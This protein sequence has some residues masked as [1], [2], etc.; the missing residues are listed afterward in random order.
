MRKFLASVGNAKL[1]GKVNGELQH[2]ADVRTLTEST[3]SFSNT[4]EEIRAGEG[5]QLMGRFS[6]DSGMTVT[7]TDAMFDLNY[8]AL[9]VGAAINEGGHTALESEEFTVGSNGQ[10][11]LKK[12]PQPIGKACGLNHVFIWVREKGCEA[13]STWKGV[14]LGENATKNVTLADYASK[15]ICVEYFANKPEA[16]GLSINANFIPAELILILTTKLFAGDANAPETGKPVGSITVKVPRFSLDGT[17]D[18]SMA[19]SAAATMSLAGTALAV[20]SGSCDGAGIYAEI[21]EVET[22]SNASTGLKDIIVDEDCLVA[23]KEPAVY[24]LYSDGHISPLDADDYTVTPALTDGKFAAGQTYTFSVKD[25]NDNDV[26]TDTV[27]IPQ[28]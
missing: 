28:A 10:I 16:R 5:A 19:M 12:T 21:I 26:V 3:L 24:G 17:F 4:Q 18:L 20:D 1:L 8:I 15:N 27:A 14:D 22:N 11:T 6:H 25:K 9:Q 13:D 2:I 7:L 23:G